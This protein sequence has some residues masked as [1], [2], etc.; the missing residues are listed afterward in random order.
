MSNLE[1]LEQ[2][3][4]GVVLPGDF[5]IDEANQHVEGMSIEDHIKYAYEQ[6][7]SELR[8][9]TSA[10]KDSA[11]LISRIKNTGLP[12]RGLMIDTGFLFGSTHYYKKELEEWSGLPID[13]FEA[14]EKTIVEEQVEKRV[15]WEEDEAA[16]RQI[17]KLE[18]MT[19]AIAAFGIKAL[20]SGIRSDQ[21][22]HRASLRRIEEGNDGE[23][24]FHPILDL[25]E[26]KVEAIFDDEDLPRHPIVK[27]DSS[28]TALGDSTTTVPGE[29]TE[30]GIH[31]KHT[32][33]EAA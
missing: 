28:Y 16:Y 31:L 5:D 1:A 23:I 4:S 22:T 12:I 8:F 10:G 24:R 33:P 2:L 32:V 20:L 6:F 13:I 29:K 15:L 9:L 19:N 25:S 26:Q 7:G 27:L 30:C 3:P 21:T 11:L 14:D 17:T 18:T